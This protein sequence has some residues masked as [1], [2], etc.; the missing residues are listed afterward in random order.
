MK[1]FWDKDLSELA[2]S[3]YD[4]VVRFWKEEVWPLLMGFSFFFVLAIPLLIV[5]GILWYLDAIHWVPEHG[6][7]KIGLDSSCR[8]CVMPALATS[9]DEVKLA[10][11]SVLVAVPRVVRSD[12]V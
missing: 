3:L 12:I 1:H 5:L 7:Y 6:V 8:A 11:H 4:G 10:A 2:D 9:L